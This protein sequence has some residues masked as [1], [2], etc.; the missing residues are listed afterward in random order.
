MLGFIG[1]RYYKKKK[2]SQV[3][4]LVNDIQNMSDMEKKLL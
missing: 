4:N 3:N 2:N 1:F